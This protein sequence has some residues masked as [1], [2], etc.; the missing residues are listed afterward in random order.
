[1]SEP[2]R[3]LDDIMAPTL[4]DTVYNANKNIKTLDDIQAPSLEDTY[5]A[6]QPKKI[7]DL[8]DLSSPTLEDTFN[9]NMKKTTNSINDV[10]AP[11]LEEDQ[12]PAYK[13]VFVNPDVEEAK[14][15]ALN[16]AIKGSLSEKPASFDQERSRQQYHELMREKDEQMARKGAK[17][18]II[19]V[20]LG[21]ICSVLMFIFFSSTSYKPSLSS[22]TEKASGFMSTCTFVVLGVSLIMLF[23][24]ETLKKLA[25]FVFVINTI[26]MFFPG[27]LVLVAKNTFWINGLL[28]IGVIIASI[29]ISFTLSSSE[30]I[31]KYYKKL[32]NNY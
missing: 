10:S 29:F 11:K 2:N 14:K 17:S 20:V 3:N 7:L 4:D 21:V 24:I 19:L 25:N 26:L 8:D 23:R 16:R 22:F 18:I 28:Y 31:D 12:Q 30:C 27:S 5:V 9:P 6:P 32:E 15:Q 1:M 13:P